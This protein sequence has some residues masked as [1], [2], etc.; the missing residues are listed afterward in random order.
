VVIA[1]NVFFY[2]ICGFCSLRSRT[3]ELCPSTSEWSANIWPGD[4][5]N[6]ERVG[7]HEFTDQSGR[8][9]CDQLDERL[10]RTVTVGVQSGCLTSDQLEEIKVVA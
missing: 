8:L 9:T 10:T 5:C 6:T 3:S 4:T 7:G 1:L 2:L